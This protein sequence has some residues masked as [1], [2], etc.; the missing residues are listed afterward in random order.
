MLF[1]LSFLVIHLRRIFNRFKCCSLKHK[2]IIVLAVSHLGESHIGKLSAEMLDCQF[3]IRLGGL[4]VLDREQPRA[5]MEGTGY[6]GSLNCRAGSPELG[7]EIG[8]QYY[9]IGD[10][11]TFAGLLQPV[12]STLKARLPHLSRRVHELED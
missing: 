6:A 1:R 3:E 9:V 11:Q 4:N 8:S 12:Q 2:D 7:A 10:A 5:A